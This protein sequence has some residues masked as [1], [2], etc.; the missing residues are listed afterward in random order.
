[1]TFRP[2][3]V[4]IVFF[5]L[6]GA[7]LSLCPYGMSLRG[8]APAARTLVESLRSEAVVE[9]RTLRE[10]FLRAR[11]EM[12]YTLEMIDPDKGMQTTTL[13]YKFATFA[14]NGWLLKANV[15]DEQNDREWVGVRNE[16]YMFRLSKRL[17]SRRFALNQ[18]ELVD[19]SDMQPFWETPEWVYRSTAGML[20]EAPF[21]VN[22]R[23]LADVL[24][25]PGIHLHSVEARTKTDGKTVG[26][27]ISENNPPPGRA[28]LKNMNVELDPNNRW[29]VVSWG[30]AEDDGYSNRVEVF[31]ETS[32]DATTRI[33]RKLVRTEKPGPNAPD[34]KFLRATYE[35]KSFE[36]GE[37][38]AEQFTL[39]HYGIR[40]PGYINPHAGKFYFFLT[41]NTATLLIVIAFWVYRARRAR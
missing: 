22:S 27:T 2:P 24:S 4:G 36:F 32:D 10:Q 1:M 25:N 26:F 21:R 29:R 7:T 14:T 34:Q 13:D 6:T 8:Q 30:I 18:V 37:T 5:A 3:R 39:S 12:A 9:L 19:E 17:K 41:V 16:R 28:P 38:S 23:D 33:P 11:G 40:E 31:Y 20:V 15:K 35:M